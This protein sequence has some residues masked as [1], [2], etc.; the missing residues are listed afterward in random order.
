[1]VADFAAHVGEGLVHGQCLLIRH[2]LEDGPAIAG[3]NQIFASGFHRLEVFQQTGLQGRF[4]NG[5]HGFARLN[6]KCG[7]LWYV[8][9]VGYGITLGFF[10]AVPYDIVA[11]PHLTA[12]LIYVKLIF[13]QLARIASWL[14]KKLKAALLFV[15][16]FRI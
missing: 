8:Q 10:F 1:M 6:E 2:D 12:L 11:L 9:I 14:A 5:F 3:Y 7:L 16:F 13:L 15:S 4:G